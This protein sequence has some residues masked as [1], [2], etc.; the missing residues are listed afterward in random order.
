[1]KRY[2]RDEK[3]REQ[4]PRHGWAVDSDN[5][6][7]IRLPIMR[8]VANPNKIRCE[9][10]L[11]NITNIL[12]EDT[13]SLFNTLDNLSVILR[14]LGLTIRNIT[15]LDLMYGDNDS[16]NKQYYLT[17]LLKVYIDTGIMYLRRLADDFCRSIRFILFKHFKSSSEKFKDLIDKI[18]NDEN[19][20]VKAGLLCDIDQLKKVLNENTNWFR[21]IRG[22]NRGGQGKKGYRDVLEHR[23]SGIDIHYQK[24][25]NGPWEIKALLRYMEES[26]L[27]SIDLLDFLKKSISELCDFWT[28]LYKIMPY[29]YDSYKFG[30]NLREGD[31]FYIIGDDHDITYLWPEI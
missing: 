27:L 1:M 11:S 25:G 9:L 21:D 22:M 28:E 4:F 18:N 8:L 7:L 12:P 19:T 14:E 6:R 13:I 24:T 26:N 17:N 5:I 3:Q 29:K 2:F 31:L 23:P 20:L 15:S 30:Q 10:G 16:K